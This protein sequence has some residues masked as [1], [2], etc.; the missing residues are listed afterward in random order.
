MNRYFSIGLASTFELLT[1]LNPHPNIEFLTETTSD[2]S[3]SLNS[4]APGIVSIGSLISLRK[5]DQPQNIR[6]F[7]VITRITVG[8]LESNVDFEIQILSE[9]VIP[10]TF[11]DKS[12]EADEEHKQALFFIK[13]SG[14][15]DKSYLIIESFMLKNG[16]TISLF[17]E[18]ESFPVILTDKKNIGL[19]YW[20][21][22]CRKLA[23]EI[24]VNEV[25]KGYDFI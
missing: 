4:K 2:K 20:H 17:I 1:S 19:G 22:E 21:F 3:L 23:E 13:R 25:K 14:Q 10:A 9:R 15:E 11:I 18:D 16:D 7:G 5:S 12:M 24:Q 8:F 6:S